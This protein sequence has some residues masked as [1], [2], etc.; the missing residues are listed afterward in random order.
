MC[1]QPFLPFL[2]RSPFFFSCLNLFNVGNSA[3]AFFVLQEVCAFYQFS[4]YGRERRGGR[5]REAA[6]D[7]SSCAGESAKEDTKREGGGNKKN[8]SPFL[9]SKLGD[10]DA[11]PVVEPGQAV[12][13]PRGA[14]PVR[15]V[16]A[17]GA[18]VAREEAADDVLS[19]LLAPVVA[20]SGGRGNGASSSTS[21]SPAFSSRSLLR[22]L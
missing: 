10:E 3:R 14:L 20:V 19:S 7:C 6:R 4:I 17:R 18:R 2:L 21:T 1:F 9:V 13:P 5:E 12:E 11:V 22:P 15:A 16:D 8:F